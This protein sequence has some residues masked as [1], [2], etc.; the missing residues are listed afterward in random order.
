ME[1]GGAKT[2]SKRDDL[3]VNGESIVLL[4]SRELWIA[5]A[6]QSVF[7]LL[8]IGLVWK[9]AMTTAQRISA[10]FQSK[11]TALAD[12]R[13][14]ADD[15]KAQLAALQTAAQSDADANTALDELGA[16]K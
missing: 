12:A 6:V 13:K 10:L 1:T 9:I 15:A 14:D 4:T 2:Q 3:A 11:E 8:I 7:L 16:P 5:I